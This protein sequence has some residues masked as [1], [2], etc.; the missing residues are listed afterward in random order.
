MGYREVILRDKPFGYWP[1]NDPGGSGLIAR[2]YGL[3][4]NATYHTSGVTYGVPGPGAGLPKATR[5][6]VSGSGRVALPTLTPLGFSTTQSWEIW[7]RSAV[8]ATASNNNIIYLFDATVGGTPQ[9]FGLA[10]NFTGSLASETVTIFQARTSQ[11]YSGMTGTITAGW[12]HYLFTYNGS[13]GSWRIYMDGYDMSGERSATSSAISALGGSGG[14]IGSGFTYTIAYSNG[15][16]NT[17]DADYCGAA[18]YDYQLTQGQA[19]A[20]YLAGRL[21]TIGRGVAA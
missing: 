21:G 8:D 15:S 20:H 10:G 11:G 9:I 18:V 6:T 19:R 16:L 5:F 7:C 12:H 1:L 13:K 17:N 2:G 4:G 14:M 3:A